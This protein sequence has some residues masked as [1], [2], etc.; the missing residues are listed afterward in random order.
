MELT[1]THIISLAG[2]LIAIGMIFKLGAWK[3]S[4]DKNL[5]TVNEFI[6]EIRNDV[7]DILKRLGPAP[8]SSASPVRLTDL[9]VRISND[10]NA[11]NWA[12]HTA[13]QMVEQTKGLDPFEIQEKAFDK[14][15]SFDPDE[16]LL[17]KMRSSHLKRD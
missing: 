14:A 15:N 17:K 16:A 4:V 12:E 7:K 8:I 3:G 9:G 10:I 11:K 6:T 2:I 13:H 1:W 5:S